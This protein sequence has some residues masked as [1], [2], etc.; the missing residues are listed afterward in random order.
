MLE[1]K[2]AKV[3]ISVVVILV[4]LCI[5]LVFQNTTSVDTH[6]LFWTVST[7][8]IILLFTAMGIGFAAGVVAGGALA[9]KG[10]K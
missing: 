3:R 10:K 6:I 5:I 4:A 9:R 8:R 1:S 7:P 2:R